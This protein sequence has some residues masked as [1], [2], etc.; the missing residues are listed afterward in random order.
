MKKNILPVL[1][2]TFLVA[3]VLSLT[4]VGLR[5]S[6]L[7][8]DPS[9]TSEAVTYFNSI[10]SSDVGLL[11]NFAIFPRSLTGNNV[12]LNGFYPLII[13]QANKGFMYFARSVDI[14]SGDD[15]LQITLYNCFSYV[16]SSASA[17][18]VSHISVPDSLISKITLTF[19]LDVNKCVDQFG[20]ETF[21][22]YLPI[23]EDI[24]SSSGI[25]V[26]S[27]F[28]FPT[29]GDYPVPEPE[30]SEL[31]ITYEPQ[32]SFAI[33]D[34]S[35]EELVSWNPD[36][37]EDII[38]VPAALESLD[39]DIFDA[40]GGFKGLF[41]SLTGAFGITSVIILVLVISIGLM[42]VGR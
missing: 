25:T 10:Y 34:N 2:A 37:Y 21:F 23:D 41:N 16:Y 5:G 20:T 27:Y 38:D 29:E 32:F 13:A 6:A 19:T 40:A 4:V 26:Y 33:S 28:P 24:Y 7:S 39:P 30:S 15:L 22:M 17:I 42:L 31:D 35:L 11:S 8:S 36:D 3:L 14:H 1:I 18:D 9:Y 12:N